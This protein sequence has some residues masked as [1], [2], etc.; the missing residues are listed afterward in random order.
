MCTLA[1]YQPTVVW[2]TRLKIHE[3]LEASKSGRCWVL[4]LVWPRLVLRKVGTIMEANVD[5]IERD[6]QVLGVVDFLESINNTR[7]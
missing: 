6:N 1:G 7:F 2:T 3:A 5:S 4:V